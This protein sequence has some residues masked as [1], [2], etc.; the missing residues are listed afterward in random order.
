MTRRQTTRQAL[1][2]TTRGG[3]GTPHQRERRRVAEVVARGGVRYWRCGNYIHPAEP[4]DLG[5]S[6][7]PGAKVRG[8]YAGPEHRHCSRV[9]GGWKRQGRIVA[10]TPVHRP[11]AKALEFFD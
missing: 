1:G 7:A 11:R 2:R 8:L 4:W 3:Y 5:H 9:A 10:S 6:D